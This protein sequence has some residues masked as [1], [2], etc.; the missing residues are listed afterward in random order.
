MMD[1]SRSRSRRRFLFQTAAVL[2]S[3]SVAPTLRRLLAEPIRREVAG[4][5]RPTRDETTGFVHEAVAVDPATGIV[6]E[7]ED[8]KP[9][10]FYRFIPAQKS[11]LS[12]GGQLQMMKVKDN[13]DLI[14]NAE[15]N[16]VY[17]VSWVAIAEADLAHSPGTKDGGGV[18]K[19]GHTQG[20]TSFQKLE[21]CWRGN[22]RH[23][24]RW[25]VQI[26]FAS[27]HVEDCCGAKTEIVFRKSC[28][29]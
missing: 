27:A 12:A 1:Y 16:K 9:A 28:R 10:G 7:T 23:P 8:R 17:D 19:Q 4:G 26:M 2:G 14:R 6:Y 15:S 21:G 13:P 24:T 3:W 20:G 5:L 29:L 25:T 18:F 11:Q 22:D